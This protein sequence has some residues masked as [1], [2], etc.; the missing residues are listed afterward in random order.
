MSAAEALLDRCYAGGKQNHKNLPV[1]VQAAYAAIKPTLD[2][3]QL[4]AGKTAAEL[5]ADALLTLFTLRKVIN[6]RSC[7][8]TLITA[9]DTVGLLLLAR[10][11]G[12]SVAKLKSVIA[13]LRVIAAFN[14]DPCCIRRAAGGAFVR[15]LGNPLRGRLCRRF[16]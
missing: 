9:R 5:L 11:G 3:F 13:E 1:M 2:K 10:D 6:A 7:P 4:R 8:S 14:G 15:M 16:W 12:V